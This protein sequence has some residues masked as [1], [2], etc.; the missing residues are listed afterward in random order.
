[1]GVV[2]HCQH[3]VLKI[4]VAIKLLK[5][6]LAKFAV[7]R[8]RFVREAR[9]YAAL[10]H[11]NIVRVYEYNDGQAPYMVQD[12]ITGDSLRA[13]LQLEG[14]IPQEEAIPLAIQ[15]VDALRLVDSQGFVHRDVKPSNILLDATGT[16]KLADMG[17]AHD[18][19]APLAGEGKRQT[20]GSPVYMAPEQLAAA[21]EVDIRADLY[22]FGVT[23]YQMVTGEL[24]IAAR[25]AQEMVL[26]HQRGPIP[27]PLQANPEL[28]PAFAQLIQK[29]LMKRPEDRFQTP[30]ELL[31]A[32]RALQAPKRTIAPLVALCA[33]FAVVLG[34]FVLR[35]AMD[36]TE[37]VLR[38]LAIGQTEEAQAAL[39]ELVARRPTPELHYASGL[40]SLQ[41]GDQVA[42]QEHLAALQK[43]APGD[44]QAAHLAVLCQ[45]D[46]G[47]LEQALDT[48]NALVA[49][50]THKLPFLLAKGMILLRQDEH[51][52]AENQLKQAVAEVGFFDFQRFEAIDLLGRLAGSGRS[53]T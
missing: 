16:P 29:L 50:G 34:I 38:Q 2:Y 46:A 40:C 5:A 37:Q 41:N 14:R 1:M 48:A 12:F 53:P 43:L 6:E 39:A 52:Q 27:D 13:R 7:H 44:E 21:N 49:K 3:P 30:T 8:A 9:A 25:S 35:P 24:P 17:I 15:I 19:N 26:R 20:I 45:I 4:P 47:Q 33:C 23:L 32:L 28:S 11:P 51:R 31:D 10:N 36:P 42:A 22:S 18:A